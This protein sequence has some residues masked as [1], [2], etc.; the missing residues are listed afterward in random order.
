M[1]DRNVKPEDVTDILPNS[2]GTSESKSM[3]GS[4]SVTHAGK[5][6]TQMVNLYSL[7]R[8]ELVNEIYRLKAINLNLENDL[9]EAQGALI[10]RQ[11]LVNE[12]EKEVNV[13]KQINE[14]GKRANHN[15]V[16]QTIEAMRYQ[17][18]EL[19]TSWFDSLEGN[20]E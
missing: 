17:I 16:K 12:L 4:G 10:S 6:S 14:A 15:L 18:M 9:Q 1:V 7:P 11:R 19:M 3:L 20:D 5:S 8:K 13:L 2:P